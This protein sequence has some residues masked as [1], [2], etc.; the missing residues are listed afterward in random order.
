M[1]IYT[2]KPSGGRR[3]ALGSRMGGDRLGWEGPGGAFLEHFPTSESLLEHLTDV[4]GLVFSNR[5]R[6]MHVLAKA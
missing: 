3:G 6:P 1:S 5:K 4:L 2:W